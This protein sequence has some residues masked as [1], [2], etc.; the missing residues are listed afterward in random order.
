MNDLDRFNDT[1]NYIEENLDGDLSDAAITHI[2][3]CPA[4]LFGRIFSVLGGLPLGEYIR[5]RRLS[6]AALDLRQPHLR[7]IDVAVKYG[8]ESEDAFAAAFKRFHGISPGAARKE[9]SVRVLPPIR[10]TL[11]VQGGNHMNV[12]IEKRGPFQIA[13]I[14]LR[15]TP[16]ADFTDLWHQLFS[17]YD[18]QQ[19]MALGDGQSYGACYDMGEDGTFHYM[20]GTGCADAQ[21][22]CD[23][24]LEVIQVPEATYAAVELLGPM[25]QCIQEGWSYV[26]GTFLPQQ[27]YRHAGTPDFEL[28]A[29][30]DMQSPDYRMELWVPIVTA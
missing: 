15:G 20:A 16:E 30:G 17:R 4:A 22:A 24:G 26:W 18:M 9:G 10:F 21:A 2:A 28:Y 6:R 14:T 11:R 25:P 27:G 13:G 1:L 12:R 19:L 23:I 29:Q 3:C 8:Y 7:V 5:L